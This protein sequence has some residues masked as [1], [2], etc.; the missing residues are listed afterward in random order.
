MENGIQMETIFGDG[1]GQEQ[2]GFMGKLLEQEKVNHRRKLI[3]DNVYKWRTGKD[4]GC[5]CS[6]LSRE[7]LF[8]WI[9]QLMK[10]R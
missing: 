7:G 10:E 3:H 9:Y 5:L 1:S 8:L 4:K 2:G 6:S